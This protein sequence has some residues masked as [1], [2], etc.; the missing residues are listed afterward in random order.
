MSIDS[1]T[2]RRPWFAFEYDDSAVGT[3]VRECQIP[4]VIARLLVQRNISTVEEAKAFLE[5]VLMNLLEPDVIPD[6]DVAIEMILTVS[7][8]EGKIAVYGDYDVD[9]I[10]GTAVLVEMLNHL[11]IETLHRLPNRIKEGYGLHV[12]AVEELAAQEVDLIITVDGG[13]NDIA[14]L[15]RSQELGLEVIVTDHHQIR[16]DIEGVP[17]VHPGRSDRPSPSLGLCGAG[18]AYKLAWA[19][20]RELAGGGKVDNRTRDLLVELLG[21]TSLGTVADMVPL[22]GENRIIVRH[23]LRSIAATSRPGLEALLETCNIDR[24]ALSAVDVGF[25]IAPHLNA[26]GRMGN[27]EAALELLLTKDPV[28]GKELAATLVEFNGQRRE[29]EQQMIEECVEELENGQH[30]EYGPL[31][32]AREG[33]HPGVAGIVAHRIVDRV[34]RP[35]W[36][37]CIDGE[38]ARGSGRSIAE[39]P[40]SDLYSVMDTV[41]E[42]VG[43]HSAAGGLTVKTDQ[44]SRLREVLVDHQRIEGLSSDVPPRPYDLELTPAEIQLELADTLECLAPFGEG[45]RQPLF[46]IRGL[47]LDGTPRLVGAGEQHIQVSF[48]HEGQRIPAIWFRAA[49]R[50]HELTAAGEITLVAHLTVNDFRGRNVQLQI[51]DLIP[52]E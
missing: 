8:A 4:P 26:A 43:G 38:I 39:L 13:S 15:H 3:L 31:V 14:A 16:E 37:L 10:S 51:V 52:A 9:G 6:I 45:N 7:E 48:R 44:I 36:V 30:P 25:R 19:L 24:K 5:P 28:R 33:W 32:F 50:A 1:G 12:T 29:I 41:V 22:V 20:A 2:I 49:G 46:C 42:K 18:V 34:H 11:G 47:R 17:L 23:G 35:V 40:L 21:L 27:A